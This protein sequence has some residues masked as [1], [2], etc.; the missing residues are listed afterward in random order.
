[1][2]PIAI[3]KGKPS[4]KKRGIQNGDVTVALKMKKMCI[5]C[6]DGYGSE[7]D[8]TR[9]FIVLRALPRCNKDRVLSTQTPKFRAVRVFPR[10]RTYT[11]ME[12]KK[13]NRNFRTMTTRRQALWS[14]CAGGGFTIACFAL[15]GWSQFWNVECAEVMAL[16]VG[17]YG[18]EFMIICSLKL[19]FLCQRYSRAGNVVHQKHAL[20]IG[21]DIATGLFLLVMSSWGSI[22]YAQSVNNDCSG[23][24]L[25]IF[26]MTW[27]TNVVFFVFSLLFLILWC[28]DSQRIAFVAVATRVEEIQELSV[29]N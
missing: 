17:L 26:L 20:E 3:R 14:I 6:H 11:L 15:Y 27:I 23:F 16:F 10:I 5:S 13:E 18:F 7:I 21:L 22:V 28:C 1:M 8:R 24:I 12:V 2:N 19:I 25:Q 29:A 4:V 9:V